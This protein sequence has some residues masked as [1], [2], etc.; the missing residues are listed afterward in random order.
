[1]EIKIDFWWDVKKLMELNS[2]FNATIQIALSKIWLTMSNR[3]KQVAPY[4]TWALRRSISVN[5]DYIQKGMVIVWSPLVYANRREFENYKN[6]D[7]KYYIWRWYSENVNEINNIIQ[8]TF[9]NN[10]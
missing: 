9:K 5:F 3:S 10:L 7:R 1:M 4:Q 8:N 6:P 2:K